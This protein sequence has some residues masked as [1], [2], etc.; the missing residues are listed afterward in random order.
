M[1][2]RGPWTTKGS[3]VKYRNYWMELRED[4]VIAPDGTDTTYSY[5][6]MRPGVHM[7]PI[8]DDG[9]VYLIEEF[10]YPL[11][12]TVLS[13][14][15]GA[16]DGDEDPLE[17][18]KR[19]LKEEIGGTA[20]EWTDLGRMDPL[21]SSVTCDQRLFLAR[22]LSFSEAKPEPIEQITMRKMKFEEALERLMRGEITHAP[23]CVLL[24]K[25]AR[26]LGKDT[27]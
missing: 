4:A 9:F 18:A 27:V 2:K 8:D 11:G 19:E 25:A 3:E 13:V 22:K 26:F 7:L 15:G 6:V 24:L 23:A 10:R 20:E 17:T 14:P 21:V 12:R 5:V 1:E 16:T